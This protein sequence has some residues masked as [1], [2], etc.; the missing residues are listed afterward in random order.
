MA[1]LGAFDIP[2]L[3]AHGLWIR[4]SD[5]EL[6]GKD[7]MFAFCPKTYMK[8]GSGRGGFF[9][10]Y[11]SLNF[12]FG[13]DGAAS[14][15]T[16]N[17][18][19][20]ARLF[21]LLVKFLSDDGRACPAAYIWQHLMEGHKAFRFGA[22]RLTAGAPADLVIWD[23]GTPDTLAS[24]HPVTSILYSSNSSN[25]RYT[26]VAGQFLK[27]DGALVMDTDGLFAEAAAA[28]EALLKRGKGKASV[29]Y[30]K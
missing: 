14:S 28:Q 30:L 29:F 13:T 19:E 3:A 7:T 17:P 21:A 5:L 22:G 10:V 2:V 11:G 9:D 20:Q 27:R 16:V 6:L 23:L 4:K 8:L 25:V 15:N 12:S 26:M 24:Y 1:K 18:V